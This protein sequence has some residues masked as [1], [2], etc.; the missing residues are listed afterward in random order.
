[1]SV[2]SSYFVRFRDAFKTRIVTLVDVPGFRPGTAQQCGALIKYRQLSRTYIPT[3]FPHGRN[4]RA[5][6]T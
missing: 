1:L 6:S 5:L 2:A 3:R 4:P